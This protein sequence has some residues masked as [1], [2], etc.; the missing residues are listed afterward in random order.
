[1]TILL[2]NEPVTVEIDIT[3]KLFR[4]DELVMYQQR[5]RRYLRTVNWSWRLIAILKPL[6]VLLTVW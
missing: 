4:G 5:M 3:G 6:T 2:R 1:M